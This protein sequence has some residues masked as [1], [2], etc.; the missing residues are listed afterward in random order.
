MLPPLGEFILDQCIVKLFHVQI[1]IHS[2]C[3]NRIIVYNNNNNI[4]NNNKILCINLLIT[5]RVDTDF[6]TTVL[7]G[8]RSA[9]PPTI[10]E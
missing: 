4:N 1:Y 6:T 9:L 8:D 5:L 3:L 10:K 2:Y 7:I